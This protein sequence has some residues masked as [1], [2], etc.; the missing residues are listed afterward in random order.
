MNTTRLPESVQAVRIAGH[1]LDTFQVAINGAKGE[2]LADAI[3]SVSIV[4]EGGYFTED[5]TDDPALETDLAFII[6]H[7]LGLGRLGGFVTE[8]QVPYGSL[9][10]QP[11]QKLMERAVLSGLPVVRVGR[12]NPEGFADGTAFFIAGS[13]LTATK[14]RLLL[15]ACLMKFGSLPPATDPDNPTAQELKAIEKAT[16]AYQSV[17]D[18][19]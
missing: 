4:K 7:K 10:S 11:R 5:F 1:R 9:P 13:N 8:G 16:A 3:P 2:I 17:F 6:A 19:H 18:T 15:M 14:A 12:G